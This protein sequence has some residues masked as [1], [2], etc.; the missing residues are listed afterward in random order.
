MPPTTTPHQYLID[1]INI[2]GSITS[3]IVSIILGVLSIWL[4]VVFYR[5]AKASEVETAKLLKSIEN[6]VSTLN[7]IN[8]DLLSKAIQHLASSNS[9]MI[10]ALREYRHNVNN[11]SESPIES[12]PI[13]Q[14]DIRAA[15]ISTI[16]IL[17]TKTGR[18]I[19]IDLFDILKSSYDFGVI[20]SELN[21][22]QIEGILTWPEAPKPPDAVSSITILPKK[23]V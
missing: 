13:A 9:Q 10:D 8:N 23:Q 14:S 7:V 18:A 12:E 16:K 15:I 21:R 19:S 11:A 6:N 1:F 2:Y 20:L 22:M 3:L 17:T 5:S 4:S